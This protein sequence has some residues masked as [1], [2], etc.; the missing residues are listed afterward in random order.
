[1]QYKST[2]HAR[3]HWKKPN[4]SFEEETCTKPNT[5]TE[6]CSHRTLV[7]RWL[8]RVV[9]PKRDGRLNWLVLTQIIGLAYCNVYGP[10]DRLSEQLQRTQTHPAWWPFITSATS[11]PDHVMR[12][13]DHYINS[14]HFCNYC[15]NRCYLRIYWLWDSETVMDSLLQCANSISRKLGCKQ[16]AENHRLRN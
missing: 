13:R 15:W 9:A 14:T 3:L 12:S 5:R 16:T 4:C 8:S 10:S 7:C 2:V 1:M 11:R 6:K